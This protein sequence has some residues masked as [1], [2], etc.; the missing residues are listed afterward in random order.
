MARMNSSLF[1]GAVFFCCAAVTGVIAV[2]LLSAAA[3]LYVLMAAAFAYLY[4]Y[5]YGQAQKTRLGGVPPSVYVS[6]LAGVSFL[7]KLIFVLNLQTQPESDFHLLYTAAV[8][9]ANGDVSLLHG[10]TYFQTWAYQT[11]FVAWMSAFIR[12]FGADVTFFKVMNCVFLT[13]TNVLVYATARR[14]VSEKAAQCAGFLYMLNPSVF[15]LLPVLTNQHLSN[16]LILLGVYLYTSEKAS[17]FPRGLTLAAAGAVLALGNA[18]RPTAIVAVGAILCVELVQ[19]ADA[20]MRKRG[21]E[22]R[23]LL[24]AAS[25]AAAY[26]GLAFILSFSVKASGLNPHGLSNRLPQWK[27]VT[28]LNYESNG[29]WNTQ[30]STDIFSLPTH[31]EREDR[32]KELLAERLSAGPGKILSLFRQKTRAM[33]ISYDA[34]EWAFGHWSGS[35]AITLP[36]IGNVTVTGLLQSAAM[37]FHCLVFCLSALSCWLLFRRR[38]SG[39]L[40]VPCLLSVVFLFY[41]G[42]HL[43]IEVQQRYRDFGMLFIFILAAY[44]L[45][46]LLNRPERPAPANA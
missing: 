40:T 15:F 9:V 12:A 42:I 28:G 19:C 45:E 24:C 6:A 18:I 16:M 8:S 30:D 1:T 37:G 31:G 10:H 5:A 20:L 46:F 32:A 35:P 25:L 29:H 41:F 14:F 17:R 44:G 22:A 36:F 26:F 34:P 27:F 4:A 23:R 21:L 7:V 11:G 13:A 38:A 2:S 3:A 33:W 39:G 43:V